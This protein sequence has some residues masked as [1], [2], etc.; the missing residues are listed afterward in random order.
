MEQLLN[1]VETHNDVL[2]R[3]HKDF[4]KWCED[5]QKRNP[6]LTLIKI[7]KLLVKHNSSEVIRGDIIDYER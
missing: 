4:K 1:V 2:M 6:E 3:V 7:T 5:I